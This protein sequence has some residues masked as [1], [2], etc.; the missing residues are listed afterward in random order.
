MAEPISWEIREAA[1]D[2]YVTDGLTYD[3]VA[4]R[5]GVSVSQ[6]KRWGQEDAWGDARR[7]YRQ[8]LQSIRRDTVKLRAAKL[9]QAL[10]SLDAQDI[11]AFAALERVEASRKTGTV[12]QAAPAM[13]KLRDIKTPADAVVAL[14]EVV[15]M[16]LNRLLASPNEMKLSEVNEVKKT[17]ELIAGMKQK[18]CPEAV[19]DTA[20]EGGLTDETAN[21]IRRQIL[22]INQ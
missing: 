2:L 16:K 7:E 1:Y 5:S 12:V 18:Y 10:G 9:K 6:L 17:M 3:Q 19:D 11:Y 8:A 22:G 21:E 4:E 13:E 20:K 15:E 14:D